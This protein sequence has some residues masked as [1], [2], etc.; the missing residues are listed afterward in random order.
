MQYDDDFDEEAMF[1]ER[2]AG[3]EG[4]YK[5]EVMSKNKTPKQKKEAD[6]DGISEIGKKSDKRG[7][8]KNQFEM[9]SE[10]EILDAMDRF[11]EANDLEL[12]K[13]RSDLF[14]DD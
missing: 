5:A 7:S 8:E 9:D 14:E 3:G 4:R 2:K 11:V 10:D 13:D 6:F 12:V 1:A